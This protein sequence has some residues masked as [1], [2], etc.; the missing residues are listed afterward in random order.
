MK[1]MQYIPHP[2]PTTR[3]LF[4]ICT[5]IFVLCI[6]AMPAMATPQD[7]DGDGHKASR[8]GGDD[9]DDND[10]NRFPGN[11]EI[12]DAHHHDEDCDPNTFGYKDTD[13]DGFVDKSCCNRS[14]TGQL[15]CGSDCDDS[16]RAI[17]PASQVCDGYAVV[18]C[19]PLGRYEK[20]I[21][22]RGT[23]CVRQ[24]N[25]TGVCMVAP[26]GYIPPPKFQTFQS[27]RLPQ[28]RKTNPKPL[29]EK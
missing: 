13:S 12:C 9:C 10:I 6:G 19:G 17:Q 8:F 14:S 25:R 16:N 20:A 23:V 5:I 2:F 22:P 15:I 28:Q 26:Q 24:P 11:I 7:R 1:I 18:I 21:C 29:Q 3:P 27:R 4:C